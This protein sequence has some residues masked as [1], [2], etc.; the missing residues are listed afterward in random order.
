LPT[1]L[2]NIQVQFDGQTVPLFMVSPTQI[3]F[4]VPMA[5]RTSGNADLQV[6]DVTTGQVYGAGSVPMYVVSPAVL[7]N[8]STQTGTVRVAAV[9]N[10]DDGSVNGPSHP[11]KD[12]SWIEIYGTGQ[13][14]VPNAPAD[15]SPATSVTPT[16]FRPTVVLNA[17]S[18]DDVTCTLEPSLNH[19]YYSGLAPGLVGVWQIDVLIPKNVAPGSLPGLGSSQVSL[20]V[21]VNSIPSYD[22]TQYR[23]VIYVQ[24]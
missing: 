15:G 21:I 12:G 16:T 10:H 3:N 18:V 13:G 20:A 4:Q 24:P 2:A 19:I 5:A 8:P 22:Y 11:A 14:F 23:S 9:I 7:L 17:C 6:T 1:A